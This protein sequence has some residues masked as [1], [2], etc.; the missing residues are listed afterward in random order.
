MERLLKTKVSV[1][2]ELEE[3]RIRGILVSGVNAMGEEDRRANHRRRQ[4]NNSVIEKHVQD[5]WRKVEE[6][7][8]EK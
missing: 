4:K 3:A 1:K 2:S 8:F 6:D 7:N 5:Y